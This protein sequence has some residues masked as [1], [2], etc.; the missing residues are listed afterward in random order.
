MIPRSGT[1][2]MAT[3]K[4]QR[5]WLILRT[6][7]AR[8][9]G[10]TLKELAEEHDTVLRTIRRDLDELIALGFPIA[11]SEGA[12][13]RNHWVCEQ[14]LDV[15]Q[16]GFDYSEIL[17][18]YLARQQLEPLAGTLLWEGTRSAMRKIH[19]SLSDDQ[20]AYLNLLNELNH[21]VRTR[22]SNYEKKEQI[23]DD[24]TVACEDRTMV[25]MTYQSARSTEPLSYFVHPYGFVYYRDSIY[26]VAYSQHH[27][28]IRHFK[29]DRVEEVE[30]QSLKFEKPADFDLADYHAHTFGVY[31]ENG[32]PTKIVVRFDRSVR[33][34]ILEH[35]FHASQIVET[36]TDGSLTATFELASLQEFK[37]WILS[38]GPKAEVLAPAELRE[39][40]AADLTKCL[41][42]YHSSKPQ[43]V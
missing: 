15:P 17:S 20:R 28:E 12:H 14:P 27:E 8:R 33:Q 41:S 40:V 2:Q 42:R 11:H 31:H 32:T 10:A 35:E 29:L 1:T 7:G 3:S 19:A 4:L 38:F 39:E 24:L 6:L 13:G 26:L 9:F 5:Q 43:E 22:T 30:P 21:N 18:L 37:S 25:G 36:D 23:L 16:L 34:Y